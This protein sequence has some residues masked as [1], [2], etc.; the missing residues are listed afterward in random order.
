MKGDNSRYIIQAAALPDGIQL[1]QGTGLVMEAWM[2]AQAGAICRGEW[3]GWPCARGFDLLRDAV[4]A[5]DADDGA[6]WLVDDVKRELRPCFSIGQHCEIFL[7]EIR[8]PL[9]SGLISMVF[10][11]RTR[12]AKLKLEAGASIARMSIRVSARRQKP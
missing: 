12:S 11:P 5:T 4:T 2:D 3:T 6:L 10:S 8:Q 9:T 1:P 7:N